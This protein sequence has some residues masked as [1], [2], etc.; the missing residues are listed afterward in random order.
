MEASDPH[1]HQPD[2]EGTE[3]APVT[4][5]QPSPSE[6]PQSVDPPEQEQQAEQAAEE[7]E[8]EDEAAEEAE[9][10]EESGVLVGT[11]TEQAPG[12]GGIGDHPAPAAMVDPESGELRVAGQA[13]ADTAALSAPPDQEVE[14]PSDEEIEENRERLNAVTEPDP[15]QIERP[16]IGTE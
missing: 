3:T 16:D 15:V 14:Q 11:T 5:A 13:P 4:Q 7:H 12:V 8:S 10:T 6:D 9:S 2:A 1:A